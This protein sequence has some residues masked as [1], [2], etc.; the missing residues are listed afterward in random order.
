MAAINYQDPLLEEK[1]RKLNW[2]I[3]NDNFL[4]M[5]NRQKSHLLRIMPIKAIVDG[6]EVV[7]VSNSP[8]ISQMIDKIDQQ[9]TDRIEQLKSHYLK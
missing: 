5:C 8:R 3:N 4:L 7:I 2:E 6:G 9:I 1:L